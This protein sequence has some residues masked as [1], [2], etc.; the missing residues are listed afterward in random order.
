MKK[1][2]L[3]GIVFLA[4]LFAGTV[5]L[6]AGG[7]RT[8]SENEKRYLTS[9]IDIDMNT[10][11]NAAVAE[12]LDEYLADQFPARDVFVGINAYF[13]LLCGKNAA[14]DVIM[15]KDGRIFARPSVYDQKRLDSNLAAIRDF[16]LKFR[17]SAYILAVPESGYIYKDALPK[18]AP[19]YEDGSILDRIDEVMTDV[20]RIKIEDTL[21]NAA[22]DS[23][24]Y[25]KT[26]HH[27]TSEGSYL[28]YNEICG[29]LGLEPVPKD[30]YDIEIFGG[31]YG[32][33]WSG[34]GYWLTKPD[35][36]ELWRLDGNEDITVENDGEAPHSGMFFEEFLEKR[37]KYPV[38]LGGNH[39]LTHIHNEKAEGTL[40]IVK[41]SFAHCI[42]PFLAQHYRDIYLVDLRYYK[43]P[44][45][46]LA[47]Q[48]DAD[49][50]L[51]IYGAANLASD[52]SPAWLK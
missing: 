5:F 25:Y 24:L 10:V 34:S 37:D 28:A 46:E 49:T 27:L 12:K 33:A 15:G 40:L 16:S 39:A 6:L 26:D 35:D 2:I 21:E 29:A 11:K 32:T 44:V 14:Q 8:Y 31:F 18:N 22:A 52:S 4:V 50:L 20:C 3:P 47:Q 30:M 42:A 43:E 36:I 9:S 19:V 38:F 13:D 17:G 7:K 45:S 51:V 48:T 41:D 1:N 23:E